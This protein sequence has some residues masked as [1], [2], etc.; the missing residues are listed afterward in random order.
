MK[1]L[2]LCLLSTSVWAQV[3]VNDKKVS[4]EAW[5]QA[6]RVFMHPRCLN[7]H[8]TGDR[9]TQGDDLHVHTMNVQRGPYDH[10]MI[11]MQCSTCHQATNNESSGVPG[12]PS[13]GLAP[14]KMAWQGLTATQLCRR[15]RDP[16]QTGMTREEFIHHNAQDEL[17][18]WGWHPGGKRNPVPGTQAEFGEHVKR[19]LDS[20]AHCPE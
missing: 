3:T 20:G 16:K 9:P 17:V 12:A 14:K 11:G 6:A 18:A 4:L 7:C 19:W 13:W 5:N 8:P 1:Y 2:M 10:G 15:L